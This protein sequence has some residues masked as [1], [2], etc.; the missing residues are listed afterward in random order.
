MNM[1]VEYLG[2]TRFVAKTRTHTLISDQPPENGGT[3]EGMTPPELL[4]ASLG[5]CAAY[6][7]TQYLKIRNLPDSGVAVSVS[8]EKAKMPARLGT[9]RVDVTVP[10]PLAEQH[11][12][13]VSRAVHACLIH[14]TLLHAPTIDIAVNPVPISAS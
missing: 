7:A 14:N 13:G 5:T 12:A 8:A 1:T 11:I 3:D 4:L 9:F 10:G 6:Y 2:G